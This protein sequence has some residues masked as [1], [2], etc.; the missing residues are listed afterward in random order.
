LDKFG[1]GTVKESTKNGTGTILIN[2]EAKVDNSFRKGLK[3]S[4]ETTTP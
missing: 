3:Q 4:P 1:V 2:P